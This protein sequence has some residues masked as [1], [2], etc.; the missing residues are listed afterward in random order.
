MEAAREAVRVARE[1]RDAGRAPADVDLHDTHVRRIGDT[2]QAAGEPLL[3]AR[4]LHR[5]TARAA[6]ALLTHQHVLVRHERAL[7]VGGEGGAAEHLGL[8]VL[9][10]EQRDGLLVLLGDRAVVD[11]RGA[12]QAALARLGR[13]ERRPQACHHARVAGGASGGELGAQAGHFRLRLPQ[14][15]AHGRELRLKAREQRLR[16]ETQAVGPELEA[17]QLARVATR[18]PLQPAER[19]EHHGEH[20]DQDLGREPELPRLAGHFHGDPHGG[21]GAPWRRGRQGLVLLAWR[22]DPL[23]RRAQR[24][25]DALRLRV[26]AADVELDGR[27]LLPERDHVAVVEGRVPGDLAAVHEGPVRAAEVAHQERRPLPDD[28]GVAR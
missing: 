9:D 13:V 10:D 14:R 20:T 16:R 17:G 19:G 24:R 23:G 3:R 21:A 1:A 12:S 5:N 4:E 22:G 18:R 27:P 7:G 15:V 2:R 11:G 8:R 28:G 26:A 6:V 25:G